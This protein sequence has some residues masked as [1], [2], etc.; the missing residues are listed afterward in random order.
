[1]SQV[2]AEWTARGESLPVIAS[3]PHTGTFMP[4]WLTPRLASDSMRQQ[5]MTD[6]HLHKLYDFLPDLGIAAVHATH[7][8]FLIDLNRPPDAQ[9]LYPGRF[10]TGLIPLQTFQG[11]TV[12]AEPPT[13]EETRQWQQ[14]FHQPYHDRLQA[15]LRQTV[16]Q[17][18]RVF[19]LDLHSVASSANQLHPALTEDIYLGN[20]DHDSC[21]AARLDTAVQCFE[22][23][24]FRVACNQPYKG[25]YITAHYGRQAGVQALQIEMA[26][27]VYMNESSPHEEDQ[28]PLFDPARQRLQ[29][30]IRKL[31]Q[32]TR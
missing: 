25:G 31:V 1:M 30:I 9:P 28:Q 3:I 12:F 2:F 16:E 7:S 29:R 8:R 5:P 11:E 19:L 14:A 17:H 26:Q 4:D 6:W 23:E 15:L 27:K 10:E 13:E 22:A 21:D 18:G 32:S 24:G 20:R